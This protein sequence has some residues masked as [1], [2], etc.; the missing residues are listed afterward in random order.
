MLVDGESLPGDAL[1]ATRPGTLW[2]FCY[3]PA[4]WTV[5]FSF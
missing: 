1:R 4:K 2:T 3:R 5:S